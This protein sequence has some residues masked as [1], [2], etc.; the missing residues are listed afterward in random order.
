MEED[1]KGRPCPLW[2]IID[3]GPVMDGVGGAVRKK[4]KKD[5]GSKEVFMTVAR[6]PFAPSQNPIKGTPSLLIFIE[7][8]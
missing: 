3:C 2:F 7:S 1:G 6:N 8:T 4:N 5:Y